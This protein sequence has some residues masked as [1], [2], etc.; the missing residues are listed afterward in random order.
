MKTIA[1]QTI[2]TILE[3]LTIYGATDLINV[4]EGMKQHVISYL[5]KYYTNTYI[6]LRNIKRSSIVIV[7]LDES[8]YGE[9]NTSLY[10][11]KSCKIWNESKFESKYCDLKEDKNGKYITFNRGKYYLDNGSKIVLDMDFLNNILNEYTEINENT[12]IPGCGGKFDYI[13]NAINNIINKVQRNELLEIEEPSKEDLEDLQNN[14]EE[15]NNI[16]KES[17]GDNK[18]GEQQNNEPKTKWNTSV[19]VDNNGYITII[20]NTTNEIL[21]SPDTAKTAAEQQES[22][23]VKENLN[24]LGMYF[25]MNNIVNGSIVLLINNQN[26]QTFIA[27]NSDTIYSDNYVTFKD[28]DGNELKLEY[29]QFTTIEKNTIKYN[30]KPLENDN[31]QEIT[32]DL[33]KPY[34]FDYNSTNDDNLIKE[35]EKYMPAGYEG[36]YKIKEVLKDRILVLELNA[37]NRNKVIKWD[38]NLHCKADLK[39]QYYKDL[40][41]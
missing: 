15:Y 11:C 32:Y 6:I 10:V 20:D 14:L 5:N 25:K 2:E 37:W 23:Q 4:F 19:K 26:K 7:D 40:L 3:G 9:N 29:N 39:K 1:E 41:K 30:D 35:M 31:K 27:S 33:S 12:I 38:M 24:N 34:I 8:Y 18:Q 16:V 22:I 17:L 21:V 13:I 36:N 28:I